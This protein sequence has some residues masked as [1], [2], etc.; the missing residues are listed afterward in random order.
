MSSFCTAKATHIFSAKNFSIQES[1]HLPNTFRSKTPKRKK[2]ALKVTAPQSKHYKQKAK[3]TFFQTNSQT[4]I[5]NKT[6][7]KTN[8]QRQTITDL[9]NHSR[10]T[11]LERVGGGFKSIYVATTLALS[12]VVVYTRRVQV[13]MH[14]FRSAVLKH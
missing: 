2:D 13:S 8:M 10:S 1:I 6:Y 14:I 7:T 3:R 4:A 5:Q 9:V 11:A 12:S